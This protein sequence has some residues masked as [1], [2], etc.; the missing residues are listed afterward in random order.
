[1]TTIIRC[2]VGWRGGRRFSPET[3]NTQTSKRLR[4]TT[5][6]FLARRT[7][8][9]PPKRKLSNLHY[10]MIKAYLPRGKGLGRVLDAVAREGLG[11][12]Q[13]EH[14]A[15]EGYVQ[16]ERSDFRH[17]SRAL[18]ALLRLSMVSWWCSGGGVH[19]TSTSQ[20]PCTT[21][22]TATSCGVE[23]GALDFGLFTTSFPVDGRQQHSQALLL[24]WPFMKKRW[25]GKRRAVS[26]SCIAIAIAIASTSSCHA[27]RS[28]TGL[29]TV[30][31]DW[32]T[33][34]V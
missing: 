21:Y 4:K 31:Q 16:P 33:A 14:V 22:T 18:E 27:H 32:R 8:T 15:V 10:E 23:G 3:T 6:Q 5:G 7:Y 30:P 20:A 19:A 26:W 9:C 34:S 11:R 17:E 29:T 12:Q 25:R 2:G 24:L 28:Q 1:M 13:P